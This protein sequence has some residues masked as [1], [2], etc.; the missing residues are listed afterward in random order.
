MYCGVDPDGTDMFHEVNDIPSHGALEEHSISTS[1]PE[2]AVPVQSANDILLNS[3]LD[4]I[5]AL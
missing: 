2:V 5:S 3:M 4:G 1:L